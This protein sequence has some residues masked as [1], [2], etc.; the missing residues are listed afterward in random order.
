MLDSIVVKG[1]TIIIR[2]KRRYCAKRLLV[3]T[4]FSSLLSES[5]SKELKTLLKAYHS[6][7]NLGFPIEVRSYVIP[8]ELDKYIKRLERAI[9][10]VEIELESNPSRADLRARLAR[11][12]KI[13]DTVM[14]EG[15]P[16]LETI[17]FYAV[18][19]CSQNKEEAI[20]RA[21]IRA[22]LLRDSLRA[23]GIRL[24]DIGGLEA[25]L[26]AKVF[27]RGFNGVGSSFVGR[28][29][30]KVMARDLVKVVT[31][32]HLAFIIPAL[33][34]GTHRRNRKDGIYLGRNLITG[35][36][37]F[38]NLD[39]APSPHIVVIGPTGSGKTELLAHL[40]AE[41]STVYGAKY[42]V[43]DAKGEYHSRLKIRGEDFRVVRLENISLGIG[44]LFKKSHNPHLISEIISKAFGITDERLKAKLYSV[45]RSSLDSDNPLE[46]AASLAKI[47]LDEYSSFKIAEI[48]EQ[49]ISI[50]S[51]KEQLINILSGSASNVV[52]DISHVFVRNETLVRI[53]VLL[54]EAAM[55]MGLLK[56]GDEKQKRMLLLD[57]AWIYLGIPGLVSDLMR[58]SRSYGVAVAIATQRVED[59]NNE[60]G[61]S[62]DAGLFIAMSSPSPEYWEKVGK[63][64]RISEEISEIINVL[65]RGEGIVRISPE[66]KA[67]PVSF[68][69]SPTE[70]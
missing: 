52:I 3:A 69:E 38:W 41:M 27:F 40:A 2:E 11:L 68:P 56:A 23:L 25:K 22:K 10:N 17:I 26:A 34:R 54:L 35:E 9:E 36:E 45:L 42:I 53:L 32:P 39:N 66:Q 28:I 70:S 30:R 47:T 65:D 8:I 13:R 4:G 49:V 51:R 15:V 14:R 46:H 7:L 64:I 29:L 48:L 55:K 33:I 63:Y 21:E 18:E 43:I 44:E 6:A 31:T 50:D 37:V 60:P 16:P 61:L 5:S 59:I 57:E 24:K 62:S 20:R 58:I 12:K 19:A 67:I 1:N